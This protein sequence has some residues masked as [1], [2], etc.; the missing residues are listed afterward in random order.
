MGLSKK[1]MNNLQFDKGCKFALESDWICKILQNVRNLIFLS[2]HRWYFRKKFW[3]FEKL[4]E[5][6]KLPKNETGRA[7]NLKT[8]KV[9]KMSFLLNLDVSFN[10]P[11]SF[12]KIAKCSK[13]ARECDWIGKILKTFGIWVF[14][15]KINGFSK[16]IL[17]F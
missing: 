17:T 1:I 7:K 10:K 9:K 12:L 16:K 15:Q 11:F 3:R 6:A 8:F 4:L 14:F 5:P 13:F 2:K